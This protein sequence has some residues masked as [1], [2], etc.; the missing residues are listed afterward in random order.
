LATKHALVMISREALHNVVKHAAADHID[1]VL[2]A[3]A[4]HLVLV[5]TDDGRGFDPARQRPGHFGLQSMRERATAVAGVVTLISA[6]GVG[7][8]VRVRVPRARGH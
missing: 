8:Q 7:T 3:E 4:E 2:E 6:E 5:I 1:I